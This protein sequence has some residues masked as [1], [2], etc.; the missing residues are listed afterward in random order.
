M[1]CVS[2]QN[3]QPCNTQFLE[4]PLGAELWWYVQLGGLSTITSFIIDHLD[5]ADLRLQGQLFDAL[6]FPWIFLLRCGLSIY[7]R[8][9]VLEAWSAVWKC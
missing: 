6:S 7:L 5:I 4:S 1:F 3:L 2:S 9:Y 8:F